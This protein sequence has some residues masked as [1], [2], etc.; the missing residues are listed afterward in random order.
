[1]T[2]KQFETIA[3]RYLLPALGGYKWHNG[4]LIKQPVQDIAVGFCLERSGS[5]KGGGYVWWFAQPLYMPNDLLH[6]TYGG[7]IAMDDGG[8]LWNFTAGQVDRSVAALLPKLQAKKRSA[9]E[10]PQKFYDYYKGFKEQNP[11]IFSAVA[12]TSYRTN[13]PSAQKDVGD[14]IAFISARE[15]LSLPWV[16]KMLDELILLKEGTVADLLQ[17]YSTRS[18]IVLKLD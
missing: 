12:Y 13:S 10:D 16:K 14:C 2:R 5:D 15:D 11:H 9:L 17:N 8:Q 3:K 4:F 1:M 7:R 6:L 18:R